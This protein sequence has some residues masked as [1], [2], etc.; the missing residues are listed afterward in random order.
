MN[1]KLTTKSSMAIS[2]YVKPISAGLIAGGLD[3]LTSSDSNLEKKLIFAGIVGAGSLLGSLALEN[4]NIPSVI[5]NIH[6]Y[7]GKQIEVKALE[8][9]GTCGVAYGLDYGLRGGREFEAYELTKKFAI[10]AIA[11]VASET[12][13]ELIIHNI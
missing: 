3:F 9:V 7:T 10:V 12:L 13:A 11:E 5:P 6:G 1:G 2:N 4:I 8:I